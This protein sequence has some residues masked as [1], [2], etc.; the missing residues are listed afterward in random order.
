MTDQI[1]LDNPLIL[2]KILKN[3]IRSDDFIRL[4]AECLHWNR[5]SG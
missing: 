3:E 2:I 5:L 4:P 1:G